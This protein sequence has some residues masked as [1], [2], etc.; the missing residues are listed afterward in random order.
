MQK[1]GGSLPQPQ[2]VHP[3]GC[4][5]GEVPSPNHRPFSELGDRRITA[6]QKGAGPQPNEPPN[7]QEISY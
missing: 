4:K 1:G 5:R 7:H 2:P 3:N 6:D